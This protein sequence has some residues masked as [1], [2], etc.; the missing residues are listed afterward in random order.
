VILPAMLIIVVATLMTA[1]PL[2]Q[3]SLFLSALRAQGLEYPPSPVRAH[4]RR[5]GVAAIMNRSFAPLPAVC[6][7]E[8]ARNALSGRPRWIVVADA[9]DRPLVVLSAGDLQLQLEEGVEQIDLLQIPARRRDVADIDYLATVEEAQT[10]LA[11]QGA[12]ALCVRRTAAP[13]RSPVRGIIVQEDIDNYRES[14]L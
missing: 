4:L 2:R 8:A 6:S 3:S 14:A 1:V 5:V 12:E 9:T 7:A 10:A 13:M 11:A